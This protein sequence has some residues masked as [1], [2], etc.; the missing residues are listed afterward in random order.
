MRATRPPLQLDYFSASR[1]LFLAEFVESTIA[2]Q[3]HTP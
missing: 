3:R 1:L 2:A